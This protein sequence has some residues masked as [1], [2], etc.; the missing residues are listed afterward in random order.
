MKFVRFASYYPPGQRCH[1]SGECKLCLTLVSRYSDLRRGICQEAL[2]E[3]QLISII[4]CIQ[5]A[6][7]DY[8]AS[9]FKAEI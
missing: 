3:P 1:R 4:Y 8:Y 6:S 9:I 2:D 5:S 7:H